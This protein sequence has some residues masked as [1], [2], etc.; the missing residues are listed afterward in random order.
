VRAAVRAAAE[1]APGLM[2][3][4]IQQATTAGPDQIEAARLV[5]AYGVGKPVAEQEQYSEAVQ[6]QRVE[7]AVI[8]APLPARSVGVSEIGS[9][10]VEPPALASGTD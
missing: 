1:A 7:L 6:L 10:S 9:V 5:L 8:T 3:T 2:A 4:L